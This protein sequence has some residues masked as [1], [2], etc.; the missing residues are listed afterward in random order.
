MNTRSTVGAVLFGLLTLAIPT[1]SDAAPK[2]AVLNVQ[3]M[4][5][6]S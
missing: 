4:V 5:C 1:F 2:L 3:G 6:S